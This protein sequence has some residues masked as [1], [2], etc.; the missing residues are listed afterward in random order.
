MQS[1]PVFCEG[2]HEPIPD[3]GLIVAHDVSRR[4]LTS[5]AHDGAKHMALKILFTKDL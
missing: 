4:W 2:K 5:S 1:E 3:V